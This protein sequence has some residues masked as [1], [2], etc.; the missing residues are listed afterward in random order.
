[1]MTW[2]L[3]LLT[4]CSSSAGDILCAR[5]MAEGG[6]L[7]N[8][9]P[10]SI[11]RAIF[12]RKLVVLGFVGYATAFFSLLTLL[13]ITQLSIAVP[14]TA[15][16]F[17]VDTIGARFLLHEHVHW[18]RWAGVLLVT[19]GVI[20]TVNSGRGPSLPR[21]GIGPAAVQADQHQPGNH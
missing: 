9:R 4:V 14:A 15:L 1:M 17:V 18:K 2:P 3:I 19:G 5:G 21:P 11:L 12:R 16:G 10:M 7:E 6:E 20:L 13:S 8:F